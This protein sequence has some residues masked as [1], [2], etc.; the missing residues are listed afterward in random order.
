MQEQSHE[1]LIGVSI[2]GLHGVPLNAE[3]H[4]AKRLVQGVRGGIGWHHPKEYLL[5]ARHGPGPL[6]HKLQKPAP[7]T[8][9]SC[10]GGNVHSPNGSLVPDPLLGLA[11]EPCAAHNL[12]FDKSSNHPG[13]RVWGQAFGNLRNAADF[14]LFRCD[15]E[16]WRTL[17][18]TTQPQRAELRGILRAKQSESYGFRFWI[19]F[20]MY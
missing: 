17:A 20:W 19:H 15:E 18:Q 6:D 7:V 4:E 10:F 3:R 16:C 11:I 2:L 13:I 14:L 12:F 5:K 1:C 9:A 8:V